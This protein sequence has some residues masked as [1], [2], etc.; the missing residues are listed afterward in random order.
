MAIKLF[1]HGV[2]FYI[3]ILSNFY[4]IFD[5][6]KI[7]ETNFLKSD[8]FE[9]MYESLLEFLF[10]SI[11]KIEKSSSPPSSALTKKTQSSGASSAPGYIITKMDLDGKDPNEAKYIYLRKF[12]LA[13]V[14]HYAT[15]CYCNDLTK[16]KRLIDDH[17]SKL[18]VCFSKKLIDSSI[19]MSKLDRSDL[20]DLESYS[21][22]SKL[23]TLI[24]KYLSQFK[25]KSSTSSSST[26][27]KNSIVHL[28]KENSQIELQL[29]NDF[30]KLCQCLADSKSFYQHWIVN[31]L[32]EL[33]ASL[34]SHGLFDQSGYSKCLQE[35]LIEC[36][37][38]ISL[39]YSETIQ[40]LKFIF[41]N[42]LALKI[43]KIFLNLN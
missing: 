21:M 10:E 35:S 31:N 26:L 20:K 38:S 27:G 42:L 22:Q 41:F 34:I 28:L 2:K 33:F 5:S 39:L 1:V 14:F 30:E 4:V 40:V 18:A 9:Y 12:Y 11:N 36:F 8:N 43:L 25:K 24:L 17:T 19:N 29:K 32:F 7:Y 15:V 13:L 6:I 23:F 37:A 3:K 16:E